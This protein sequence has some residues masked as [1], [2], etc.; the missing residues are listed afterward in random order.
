MA[1]T[2]L[3]P[4]SLPESVKQAVRSP[5]TCSASTVSSLQIL[6]RCSSKPNSENGRSSSKSTKSSKSASSSATATRVKSSRS[7]KSKNAAKVAVFQ[8]PAEVQD[9]VHLSQQEKLVLATEVFNAASKALSDTL[10]RSASSK[11]PLQPTSPNRILTSPTKTKLSK[12]VPTTIAASEAGVVAI[13][14][15]ARLALSSLRTLKSDQGCED[16]AY[17]NLQ[18]EQGACILAGRLIAL[19][20]NDLAYRELRGLKRRLQSYM[21]SKALDEQQ[22]AERP[23][24]A[25]SNEDAT[26]RET[27]ADLLSFTHLEKARS[28]FG[29]LVPFQAN[30][31]RLIASEKKASVVQKACGILTLSNPSSPANIIMDALR[32]GSLSRDKAALQLLSLSNNISSLASLT[33]RS[34]SS[35]SSTSKLQVRPVTTLTLQLLSLE[36][37]SM[38]W[39]VSGHVCE[40]KR[41]FLDPLARFLEGFAHNGPS[42]DRTEFA[43][44]YKTVLRLQAAMTKA[45]E[46]L[47]TD[48][49]ATVSWRIS[50]ALGRLAQEAGCFEEALKLYAEVVTPV[51]SDQLLSL[52]TIRCRIA[53]IHL[54]RLKLSGNYPHGAVAQSLLEA[55]TVLKSSNKGSSND[56][57]EL[58]VES[59]KLKKLA[60]GYLGDSFSADREMTCSNSEICAHV[61]EYL[62][63]FIR[64]LR[65]YVGRQPPNGS[66]SKDRGHLQQALRR[67]KNIIIAAVDSAVAVGKMSVIRQT[68]AWENMLPIF[69]DCKHLLDALEYLAGEDSDIDENWRTSFI[70]L[71]N[72][73]WSRYLKEKESGKGCTE[74]LP[75]LEQST[76]LLQNC[77][78]T[79]RT[80]GF[81]A[82]KFERLANLYSEAN[83]GKKSV[84]AL[85][86]SIQEHI[87]SDTLGQF[88]ASLAGRSPHRFCHNAQS[89]GFVLSRVL[90]SYLK[91]KIR[92]RENDEQAIFDDKSLDFEQRSVLLEWQ[93]GLLVESQSHDADSETFRSML[94]LLISELL[95]LY[96]LERHPIRRLR[97]ILYVLR[98]ALQHPNAVDGS[99]AE[100]LVKDATS[101]LSSEPGLAQDT[102]LDNFATNIK[103]SLHLV[104]AFWQGDVQPDRLM[105]VVT[106]WISVVQKCDDWESLEAY[107]DDPEHWLAQIKAASDY[108][109]A[110]GLW[111]LNLATS[112]LLLHVMELQSIKDFSAIVL[113]LSRCALQ[114]CRLGNCR[115][116][117]ALLDRAGH[118]VNNQ[119]VSSYALVF[120]NLVLAEYLLEIGELAKAEKTLSAA[121][122]I[123][124]SRSSQKDI[125]AESG[126]MK[127]A[128]ERIVIDATLLYSRIAHGQGSLKNALFFA[129]LSVRLSSRLWAKLE[130]LSGRNRDSE[131]VAKEQS[132]IDLVTDGVANIDLSG[133]TVSS[134]WS[135]SDGAIFWTHV[136]S[137]HSCLINLM[138][139]SA[140]NGLF[141]DAIYYGEQALKINKSLD[142]SVRSVAC[143]AQLG[144]EWIRG[145]HISEAKD[146]LNAAVNTSRDMDNSIE[147]VT[148]KT[149]LAA[150]S[151][152]QGRH[153]EALRVLRDAEKVITEVSEIKLDASLSITPPA[154][155]IEEKMAEMRIQNPS[156]NKES[157]STSTRRTRRTKAS[158]K[159]SPRVDK[160]ADMRAG[161]VQSYSILQLRTEIIRQQATN[162]LA[163]Q[164]LDEAIRVLNLAQQ[165]SLPT[166]T[167]I[168]LQIEEMEHLLADSLRSVATHAVYCVLPESTLSVPSIQTSV[169]DVVKSPA[170]KKSSSARK[171]KATTR[172]PR[173]RTAKTSKKEADISSVMSKA[174][175]SIGETLRG[176]TAFGSTIESHAASRLTG[177][178]SML[179]H[180]TT[181]GHMDEGSLAAANTNELGRITAFERERV[182]IDIDKQLAGFSDSLSWPTSP[183]VDFETTD[184]VSKFTE[185]YID[186]LP[187]NWNVVSVSINPDRT[188][189]VISK[190]RRG[191]TP[192]LLRLPLK[193]GNEDDEEEDDEFTFDAGKQEMKEIIKLAN[194]SAHDARSRVDRNSKKEW[195]AIRE[196]LDRRLE[197]L[198]CN[199]E[200]VWL[201]G[202]RG[203]FAATRD[204]ELL[205][206]FAKSF[207]NILDKHLPS[208]R[209]AGNNKGDKVKLHQNVLE[210]FVGLRGLDDHENP[211]DSIMDLLYFVVDIL[212]FQG[213]RNA[214]DEIDFDMMVVDTL[215][216]LRSYHEA[217]RRESDPMRPNHTILILDKALHLFPWESLPCLQGLPVS[218]VPSLECLRDRI[219]RLRPTASEDLPNNFRIDRCNGAYILNPSGDLMTTQSTFEED[220][221][222]MKG[223]SAIVNRS[224]TE[225]EFKTALENKSLFLY[226]GHGSGAQYIRGRTIKRLDQCAVTFLMGCSSGS[227]TEAGELEPYGTPMNYMHAGTP[228]L[229]ATLWDVTDKDID[230][231]AKCTFEKWGL[232]QGNKP[233]DIEEPAA[234]DIKSRSSKRKPGAMKA[235]VEPSQDV[236]LDEAVAKSRDACL[237]KYLNGA[238]PVI[239]GIPV[240]LS[241]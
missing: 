17:P 172:E 234:K 192:F 119:S 213:E 61:V 204:S 209:K 147:I 1:V 29:V 6:L 43:I 177:S 103:D 72:I 53:S 156:A 169:L 235:V 139:L 199:M 4:D 67:S 136:V 146:L 77:P 97:V 217:A 144:L 14:E 45:D 222:N 124:Q 8:G 231:F 86:R 18:L 135:Y 214:Y 170:A 2:A 46:K 75:L 131:Q 155:G 57:E 107:V 33:Q 11:T 126:R 111:K 193:R 183:V 154:L 142:A 220:F 42:I 166:R 98:F 221:S 26:P 60:M 12:P 130:R 62:H 148:L 157:D 73:F 5:S 212:Q 167:Q 191:S 174:K 38:S 63:A 50:S 145:D 161:S 236:A 81:A 184:V 203:I 163:T 197:T 206:R 129:K 228:A 71:S 19:G 162:L 237:L 227:L 28:L 238:A 132:E 21:E 140:H 141:Q 175:I 104:I 116:C 186:I 93:M 94:Q 47:S 69:A 216:A 76:S 153:D 134:A 198:L 56:L 30:A 115:R 108:M 239:Y 226:F 118:Y 187:S 123:Y 202:F 55:A 168:S 78:A 66:D 95:C 164:N 59:A 37:R 41:E 20:L 200:N 10:Q 224:P 68:P 233:C 208:R 36:I 218:R 58:L 195:W 90:S 49:R 109:E 223:W 40:S 83:M 165:F 241:P 74:L 113:G 31:V 159:S 138:R 173:S 100:L 9:A 52:S 143:Q 150:L 70:K 89:P 39:K 120:Y 185:E 219:L 215:D 15:C 160:D 158:S 210:L 48:V 128:W 171:Q 176:A 84:A 24:T 82:L 133:A 190:L 122:A 99:V 205:L 96:S 32:T 201:G 152:A 232:I 13:A 34:S 22:N 51:S 151:R 23:K 178:I 137:H 80:A 180:A 149:S 229:V 114:Y 125:T 92:R 182:A 240:Y 16:N 7:A 54:H 106:S 27:T 3:M 91:T 225:E 105:N 194:A 79:D 230:R 85:R 25:A 189:F 179:L 112:E 35:A 211:E 117:L 196:S 101:S 87:D 127:L 181:P 121:Q 65:R 207:E 88:A 64:F 110:R 44:I 102:D 188:E